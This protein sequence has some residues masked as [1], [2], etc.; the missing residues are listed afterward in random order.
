[1]SLGMGKRLRCLIGN[2]YL[3]LHKNPAIKEIWERRGAI[4]EKRKVSRLRKYVNKN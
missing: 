2:E 4:C 3:K 1:M